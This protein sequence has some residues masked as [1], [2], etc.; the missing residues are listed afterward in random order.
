MSSVSSE[1]D[2]PVVASGCSAASCSMDASKCLPEESYKDTVEPSLF[3]TE[4]STA[5]TSTYPSNCSTE[6]STVPPET[7]IFPAEPSNYSTE[8]TIASTENSNC[9]TEVSICS[10]VSTKLTRKRHSSS[11]ERPSI[12]QCSHCTRQF[13]TDSGLRHHVKAMH[14]ASGGLHFSHLPF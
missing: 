3:S 5:S 11:A 10:T 1:G 7:S 12:Y 14:G 4:N 13:A 8:I 9:S 2:E 6:N